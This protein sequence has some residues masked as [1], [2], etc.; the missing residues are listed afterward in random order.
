MSKT[1]FKIWLV[2]LSIGGGILGGTGGGYFIYNLKNLPTIDQLEEYRP[3]LITY[4]YSQEGKILGEFFLERRVFIPL[5]R[6]PKYLPLAF[7]SIEDDKFY[8]HRGVNFWAILRALWVNLKE[9]RLTQGG[10]TIT[11]QLAKNL[12]LTPKKSIWR[13]IQEIVLA[14]QIERR[15]SK[16]E[17]LEKYLNQI[18]FGGGVY[19]VGEAARE[20]FGKEVEN[21]SL[22][23]AALLASIPKN[24]AYYSPLRHPEHTLQ[25]RNYVLSRM[26]QLG[27]ISREELKKVKKEPLRIKRGKG[28]R[29]YYLHAPYFVEWVRQKI[30]EKYGYDRLWR[31]GL[32]VY[33]T[34]NF[35]LQKK[36]EEAI[37]PYL[38]RNDFQGA[39]LSMNPSTGFIRALVGGRNF[40]ESQF[41]RA[42]QA[43]RQTGSAFKLFTYTAAI[44]SKRFTPVSV[45]FDAPIFF[46]RKPFLKKSGEIKEEEMFWFPQ[47]FTRTYRGKVFLW[48]ML[49]HSINVAS[50]KLLEKVGIGKV[51]SSAHRMGIESKLNPDLTLTLG[52]SSVSLLEMVRAYA[53][54]CN[55]GIRVE[56]IFIQKV[57][58]REGRVLE[59]NFPRKESVLSPQTSYVMINLLEKVVNLGTGQRIRWMG[60]TRP[61]AGKTGTVGWPGEEETDKTMDAWF[62]GFTPELVTGVWIGKDDGSPLGEKIT[63]SR[64]AIPIWVKFMKWALEDLPVQDFIPPEGVVFKK[65]DKTTGLLATPLSKET[66]WLA[67]IEGTAPTHYSKEREEPSLKEVNFSL[68][69][70]LPSSYLPSLLLKGS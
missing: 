26:Y 21:L 33:T 29:G 27:Y 37:I 56:P 48:E 12:F 16:E 51:I 45:F 11:Q 36:A 38:K 65:I 13:K 7:I 55:L 19:G 34:L 2:I 28:K 69:R 31:G 57:E 5:S 8:Q 35:E 4:V 3:N 67:F 1:R 9:R 6:M 15:Y 24:P 53:T 47:N 17:I 41:N 44:D 10:S 59:E 39:L 64:G 49:A 70:P 40:K 20:Y 18:Y 52:T 42:I 58:D 60:F 14:L 25:R 32:R 66:I 68:L 50:V 23:E 63:G 62:I 54:L 43:K 46:K 61:C 22:A 30:E